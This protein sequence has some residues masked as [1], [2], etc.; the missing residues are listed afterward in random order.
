MIL[1]DKERLS[2][3]SAAIGFSFWLSVVYFLAFPDPQGTDFYPLWVGAQAIVNGSNPYAPPTTELLR[4]S[5]S[6]TKFLHVS[7]V[8]AYPLP[9]LVF[10][11]PLTILP[12]EL[13]VYVWFL[14]LLACVVAFT[15]AFEWKRPISCL[16]P[17]ISFPLFHALTIK[18]STVLWLGLI[19]LLRIAIKKN[20]VVTSGFCIALLP[21]KPQAGLI[22]AVAA[23]IWALRN[24]RA[25]LTSAFLWVVVLW[26]GATIVKP[27]WPIEWWQAV[28]VYRQQVPL[29]WLLPQALVLPLFS[30]HLSWFAIV[31]TA[32]VIS[33]PVNDLYSSL[34]LLVGWMEIGGWLAL[35]GVSCSWFATAISNHPHHTFILWL[36]VLLP[37]CACALGYSFAKLKE[38]SNEK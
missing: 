7:D 13:A 5:W 17:L 22:F 36:T 33:F 21:G 31:A 18:T 11:T 12:L 37:Y 1:V 29:V 4:K 15:F 3:I 32:Q 35:A 26:G 8:V 19:G 16:I 34:P 10:I 28:Q 9:I 14:L 30:R 24:N 23:A 6:V 20:L 38:S 2:G 27:E 25:V